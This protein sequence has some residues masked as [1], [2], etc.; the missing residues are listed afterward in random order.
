MRRYGPG[1]KLFF[2]CTAIAALCCP[3]GAGAQ[4]AELADKTDLS[5]MSLEELTKIEVSSVARKDQELYKT[6]AAV[7]V[8]TRDDIR[9]SGVS[10]I[11]ELFRIVP[12]IQVAQVSGN[13]WAV[14]ARG[15]NSEFADKM[16]VL[17]DGRSIYSEI[18]SGVFWG[19]NDLLLEDIER[20]EV[21]RGPGG[22]LWGA[23]AV[24]GIINIIT[25]KADQT[26]GKLILGEAGR[27]DRE[28]AVRYGGQMGSK[29]QY[30]G[31]FKE[32]K[33][34]EL[35]ADDGKS[36][37]DGADE[38]L[39]GVR[40]DWQ[41]RPH[42]HLIL[43]STLFRGR[44][45]KKI[46]AGYDGIVGDKVLASTGYALSRWE[47][48]F[49][50]SD[51]ALQSYF[52]Q[53][54]HDEVEGLGRMRSLDFDFQH[55]LPAF[56]RND[57]NWG[58]G[59]RLTTDR[60]GGIPLTFLHNHHRDELYSFFFE[61]DLTLV[62]DKLVLTGGFKLQHNSY[63]GYEIQPGVRALWSPDEH[64]ALWAAI[65]RAVRTPSVQDRD[66]NLFEQ[67]A[68]EDDLPTEANVLGNPNFHS[69][70]LRA[71]EG[72]YRQQVGKRVSADL[73]GFMNVY[74]GL[75]N[76]AEETPYVVTSPTP[77]LIVPI[78]YDNGIN[79]HTHGMEAAISWTPAR[80]L[81][82]QASYSWANAHLKVVD[83]QNADLGD[84]WSS[85][86]NTLSLRGNWAFARRWNFYSSLYTVSKLEQA[87]P[88]I[89]APVKQ[90][91]RFDAH[92]SCNLLNQLQFSTGGDNLFQSRHPEFDPND[93]FSVRSQIPRSAFIKLIWSF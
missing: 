13:E 82:I 89:S 47:H 8:I 43:K 67:I 48:R 3:K 50:G 40:F 86:T 37:H 25:S 92:V 54:I 1:A 85:P 74:T 59:F 42:D 72:G 83:G 4:A 79:A 15:F 28:G 80:E 35:V 9:N 17:I 32:L 5:Q 21:I 29:L 52:T 76:R 73:A 58:T 41:A 55:H 49:A 87:S 88:I 26:Q 39:G 70:V 81:R 7:Y 93:S 62:P 33:R 61:D 64:H 44:E 23:N 22:T 77:T 34:N 38:Q 20:I 65:S 46:N 27:M 69:E 63:T 90:Y 66:L 6:P 56:W 16:L 71:Y 2:A 51:L 18:Y 68:P 24:N 45:D 12:G 60:I 53:E 36:A 11:P 57:I 31:Y 10:S 19:Q 91:A 30:R 14:S 84:T 75:R 78:L